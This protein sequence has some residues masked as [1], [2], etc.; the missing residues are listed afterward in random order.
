MRGS[1]AQWTHEGEKMER[2]GVGGGEEE[3]GQIR[4]EESREN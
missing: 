4:Q 2:G 1:H 3:E